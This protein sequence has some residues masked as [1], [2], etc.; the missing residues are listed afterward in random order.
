MSI[1]EKAWKADVTLEKAETTKEKLRHMRDY[2]VGSEWHDS[3][4]ML[5]WSGFFIGAAIVHWKLV[6]G[7]SEVMEDGDLKGLALEAIG[8]FE[9]VLGK[10]NEAIKKVGEKKGV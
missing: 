5:E 10:V 9:R 1:V 2:Y 6:E 7:V 8:F 3:A 4:E